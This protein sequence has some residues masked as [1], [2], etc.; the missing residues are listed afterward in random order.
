MELAAGLCEPVEGL[1]VWDRV[2]PRG[3]LFGGLAAEGVAVQAPL[4]AVLRGVDLDQPVPDRFIEHADERRDGVL[5]GRRAVPLL[6]LVD[7]AV[8]DPGRDLGD[9]QMPERGQ[10]PQFQPV[11]VGL[12]C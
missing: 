8:D 11:P 9:G 6:P 2:R 4:G 7:G 1:H 10:H 3:G 5:D 12:A